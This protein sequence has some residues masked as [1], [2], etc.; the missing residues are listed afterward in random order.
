MPTA[1]SPFIDPD[2]DLLDDEIDESS[3]PFEILAAREEA[4]GTPL[5]FMDN[6]EVH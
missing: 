2:D 3:D 1:Q 6:F 4:M 5:Y